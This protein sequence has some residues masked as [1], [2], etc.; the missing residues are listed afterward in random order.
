[1]HLHDQRSVTHAQDQSNTAVYLHDQRTLQ[2]NMGVPADQ[3]I[4]RES[5]LMSQAHAAVS[6]ARTETQVIMSHAE[7]EVRAL[8]EQVQVVQGEARF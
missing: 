7:S 4:A 1:M 3:V 5:E 8:Q 2:M 6:A